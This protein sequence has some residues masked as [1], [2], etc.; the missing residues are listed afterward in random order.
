[1][2]N[3]T[4]GPFPSQVL[5]ENRSFA[6]TDSGQTYGNLKTASTIIGLHCTCTGW[7]DWYAADERDP[8]GHVPSWC[9]EHSANKRQI[10]RQHPVRA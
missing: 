3:Y 4:Y 9:P 1:M 6:K 8:S 2:I 7:H 5:F 10:R